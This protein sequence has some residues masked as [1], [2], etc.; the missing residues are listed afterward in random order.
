MLCIRAH[1]TLIFIFSM[2]LSAQAAL[3]SFNNISATQLETIVEEFGSANSHTSV[4]GANSL[5]TIFGIEAG[6]IVGALKSDGIEEI[7]KGVKPGQEFDIIPLPHAAVLLAASMPLG[8]GA[9][10]TILPDVDLQD[11][12]LERTGFAG[13]LTLTDAF[14]KI[15]LIDIA[16]KAHYTTSKLSYSQP[17]A[18]ASPAADISFDAKTMGLDVIVGHSLNL[19]IIGVDTYASVGYVNIDGTLASTVSIFDATIP[20]LSAE[21]KQS[22]LDFKLGANLKLLIFKLG[23]EYESLVGNPRYSAKLSVKF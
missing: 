19:L 9:E 14:L 8:F 7:V 3:P 12:S 1:F 6:I 23:V 5:G 17:A 2:A 16:V 18:G 15:P 22:G 4:S 10:M 21:K 20:G 11:I 13:K